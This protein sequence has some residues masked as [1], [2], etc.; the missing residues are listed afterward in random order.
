MT[1]SYL[2]QMTPAISSNAEKLVALWKEKIEATKAHGGSC[3]SAQTDFEYSTLV[4]RLELLNAFAKLV[5]RIPYQ[6]SL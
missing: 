1:S 4:S 5:P 2:N 6:K 3:F